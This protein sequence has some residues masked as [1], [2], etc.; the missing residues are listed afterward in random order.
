MN[1]FQYN[2]S[3]IVPT[4]NT[5]KYLYKCID[6]LLNQTIE[7]IEIIVVD[8]AS[9]E[10]FDEIE[11]YYSQYSNIVFLKSKI[12]SGPGGARNKGLAIAR[13][14]YIAF[15]DSDDWVELNLYETVC[16]A[17]ESYSSDIGIFSVERIYDQPLSVPFYLCNYN[18][19]YILNSDIALKILLHQYN[20][21][22]LTIPFYCTN[23]V[24]RK[25]FLD[26]I[27]ASFEENI[28]FQGKLFT[29]YTFLHA[30]KIICIPKVYYKHYRRKNSVIQSF[31]SKHIEDFKQSMLI[32]QRY[33]KQA[34]K[35][36]SFKFSYYKLCEKSLDVV[37]RQIFEF[38][39]D[40]DTKKEYIKKALQA[41]QELV[42]ID[43]YFEYADAEEIRR[44]IQPYINDTTLK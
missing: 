28:Y 3:V 43:D 18:Q 1:T 31:E 38:V 36:E 17:M 24:F 30:K 23:K 27:H 21:M 19:H 15:C 22:G 4:Y 42:T 10:P 41:M 37:I 14:K 13:G 16:N 26:N 33:L 34:S 25:N 29:I 5:S 39:N 32:T 35:Y 44:H 11:N 12:H 40:D 2:I 20:G 7:S 8:D 6:S 9:D